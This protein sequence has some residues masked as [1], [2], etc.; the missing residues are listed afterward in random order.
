[1]ADQ[2][3]S[4]EVVEEN[5]SSNSSEMSEAV[6]SVLD[7]ATMG[8]NGAAAPADIPTDAPVEAHSAEE[9]VA[10]LRAE[11]DA[12]RARYDE[13]NDRF[14]RSSA[15]FQ[16]TLR[17]REKQ[18]EET[19]QRASAYIVLKLLPVIDDFERAFQTVPV[20]ENGENN[21]WLDG[22]KQ[23]QKK[24]SAVLE[25]EG[26]TVIP[27]E[28]E[29]DPTRHEAISSEPSDSVPSGVIIATLRV[30]YEQRGRVLRP[31]LVRVAA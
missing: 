13:L 23:I 24:L 19:V 16:N 3:Q 25:D 6:A 17:R 10:L 8:A 2:T 9:A 27:L 1:M 15:E 4:G 21:A 11:I 29:F 22:F 14:Q 28:G 12:E 18:A 30:G 7:E 26:V 31:A 20:G 5:P